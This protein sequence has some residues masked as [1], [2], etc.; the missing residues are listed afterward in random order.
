M[1]RKLK[2]KS[3]SSVLIVAV[4]ALGFIVAANAQTQKTKTSFRPAATTQQPL[5]QEYRGI[6][7]G[8][9]AE[10]ARAKLGKAALKEND[11]DFYV[12]SDN[13][14]IQIVYNNQQQVITISIDYLGGVGAPDPSAVVGGNLE[15]TANGALYKLVRYDSLGFWVSYNRTTGPVGSVT[16]T[17]Q[18]I[19]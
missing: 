11:Q 7:L 1:N 14:S 19:A 5:F 9:S 13:E 8:M 2:I 16:I 18:K 15:T 12:V 3:F 6:K 10:E 17:L 4:F